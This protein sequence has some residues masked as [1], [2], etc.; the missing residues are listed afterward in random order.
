MPKNKVLIPLNQSEL[1]QKIFPHVEKFISTRENELILFYITKPP[2]GAGFG[3]TKPGT[4]HILKPGIEQKEPSTH[5]IFATQ[6]EDSIKAH[7]EAEL[8]SV[9]NHLKELG[10]DISIIVDFS[11]EPVDEILAV[12]KKHDIGLVAMSS[13][14]RVGLTRFFFQ[15]IADT[16]A[17]KAEIPVLL[18]HPSEN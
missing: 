1:S 7:V 5:P 2:R 9:S 3:A 16:L 17:R 6:Q 4:G 15:D 12:V 11:K 14:A 18:I 13:R 8:M 10:Y